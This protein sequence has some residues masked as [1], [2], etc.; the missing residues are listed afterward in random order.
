M[1]I[2][3]IADLGPEASVYFRW[4]GNVVVCGETL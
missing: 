4:I 1:R 3:H 2:I